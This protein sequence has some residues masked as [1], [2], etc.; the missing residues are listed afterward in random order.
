LEAPRACNQAGHANRTSS[1]QHN[2]ALLGIAGRVTLARCLVFSG[3]GCGRV[4]HRQHPP[5]HAR[6]SVLQQWQKQGGSSMRS[7]FDT[8]AAAKAD[9][10]EVQCGAAMASF[11]PEKSMTAQYA[12]KGSNILASP[13]CCA[14]TR[15]LNGGHC[16]WAA[17]AANPYGCTSIMLRPG[18][19]RQALAMLAPA[20]KKPRGC[21]NRDQQTP[22]HSSTAAS[23][24][25]GVQAHTRIPLQHAWHKQPPSMSKHSRA[26]AHHALQQRRLPPAPPPCRSAGCSSRPGATQCNKGKLL[27][28]QQLRGAASHRQLEHCR[29]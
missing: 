29:D 17:P 18:R 15:M 6:G 28:R 21:R 12:L 14:L 22:E 25:S 10:N 7:V 8:C 4:A 16:K 2:V 3:S 13:A 19:M 26:W 27:A 1:P 20:S 9:S 24:S 11:V 5:Q 23:T